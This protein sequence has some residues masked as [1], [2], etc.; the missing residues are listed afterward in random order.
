MRVSDEDGT[1][2]VR[3]AR[4]AV[5]CFLRKD[6]SP[7]KEFEERFSFPSG[8]FVTLNK[9]HGLRGCIGYPLPSKTLSSALRDAAIAA[10]TDDPRFA[11]VGPEELGE[12]TFEVTVLTEPETIDVKGFEEYLEKIRVGRDGLLIRRGSSSGLLLPQV[13]VEYD[14][15]EREFLEHTCQKAGLGR[16]CWK[17]DGVEVLKFGGIVFAES[18]PGGE[19]RR[20][21]L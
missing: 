12:I 15:S 19:V 9:N 11:P 3:Q 21:E 5:E 2:L 1:L 17:Q 4:R 13:P 16:D 10:A 6:E 14:W 8:V 20:A 18:S 7:D